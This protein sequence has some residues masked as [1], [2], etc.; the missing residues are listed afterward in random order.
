[1]PPL[2]S[3]L[4]HPHIRLS[5]DTRRIRVRMY[6][7]SCSW[8][9][10]ISFVFSL[11]KRLAVRSS[12]KSGPTAG[13]RR[14]THL[15]LVSSHSFPLPLP[16][17]PLSVRSHTDSCHCECFR[18]F[19]RR[20]GLAWCSYIG[21]IVS[22]SLP[23]APARHSSIA[24]PFLHLSLS[25]SLFPRHRSLSPRLASP[26]HGHRRTPTAPQMA[27]RHSK[28]RPRVPRASIVHP[29]SVLVAHRHSFQDVKI[30]GHPFSLPL[31]HPQDAVSGRAVRCAVE[32]FPIVVRHNV[33]ALIVCDFR[34]L[35]S[36][37]YA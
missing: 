25:R 17:L 13:T 8:L 28:K 36:F 12:W 24:F 7:T 20:S 21:H 10:N 4:S 32:G 30:V 15:L 3:S 14:T 35:A 22:T 31:S 37:D 33:S 29:H 5:L 26:R 11:L 1:M 9:V 27:R 6:I 23:T 16:F 34:V 2:Y 19:Q 18:S